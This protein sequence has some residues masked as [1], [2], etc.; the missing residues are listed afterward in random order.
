MTVLPCLLMGYNYHLPISDLFSLTRL[1]KCLLP[2]TSIGGYSVSLLWFPISLNPFFNMLSSAAL[3]PLLGS[4][5]AALPVAN[6]A[7]APVLGE[8]IAA[9]W[10]QT[11]TVTHIVDQPTVTVKPRYADPGLLDGLGQVR[12]TP[13]VSHTI[14]LPVIVRPDPEPSKKT[15]SVRRQA[16]TVTVTKVVTLEPVT[17][18]PATTNQ[19]G[20]RV[21]TVSTI[22]NL[23][24]VTVTAE[25]GIAA[26][27]APTVT[28]IVTL[29]T[30]TVKPGYAEK[31][32]RELESQ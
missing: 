8:G 4:L 10:E 23:P 27:K 30:V 15:R 12:P 29:P 1:S 13:T 20:R 3:L 17:I 24:T 32:A 5:V 16:P 31:A 2:A 18:R 19:L 25:K 28:K 9:R 11:P 21:Q 7:P 26:R 22:V 14:D 6:P